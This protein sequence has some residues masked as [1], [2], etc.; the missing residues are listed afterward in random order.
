MLSFV[1]PAKS[2]PDASPQTSLRALENPGVARAVHGSEI[3][4]TVRPLPGE[5]IEEMSSR[6]AGALRDTTIVQMLVF[7]SVSAS[8]ASMEAMRRRFGS[9]DWP[10]TWVEGGA[11]DS[12]PIAGIQIFGLAGGDA[13]RI[14]FDGRVVGSVYNDGA[15]RHCMLGGLRPVQ[16]SSSRADQTKQTLEQ[17]EKA[18]AQAG[19]RLADTVRTWFFLEDILSWYDEF[20]HTRTQIYSG[21][22]F[23]AGSLPAS[24][25][26]GGRN[27]A[28]TALAVSAWAVQPL[29]G[30]T[31]AGEIASPFQCPAPD[32]GSSFSRAME[33]SSTSGRRLLVSGTASIAPRG[34]TL[35]KADPRR[36]VA[37]T[38][39]VVD[40][41]FRSRDF[42]FADL[43]RA[44]AYFKRREDMRTFLEWC[45]VHGWRSL[46][47]VPAHCDLCRHDLMF[48]IEAD[49]AQGC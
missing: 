11:C 27:P 10:V 19:F 25:G 36:Q 12:S 22:K 43:T 41:I 1:T 23:R 33:I 32:Y 26:V 44:T 15:M 20:N 13:E 17:L 30:S 46:P 49:A 47:V 24:T 31:R 48:E 42:S 21:V 39:G 35:W 14:R 28:G 37:L 6:L 5:G 2:A 40:A 7:G 34:Q 9:V 4:L 45:A 29:D 18:L 38:M 16:N 3:S 8:A